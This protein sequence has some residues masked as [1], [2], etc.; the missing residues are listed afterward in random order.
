[1]IV[2]K[3]FKGKAPYVVAVLASIAFV[4]GSVY[5]YRIPMSTVASYLL[6]LLLLLMAVVLLAAVLAAILVIIR[7][8]L[9]RDD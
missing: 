3:L 7:K 4:V 2:D 9:S 1:M 8:L 6:T 5:M